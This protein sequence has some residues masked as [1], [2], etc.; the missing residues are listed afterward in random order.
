ML[1]I[2]INI[3]PRHIQLQGFADFLAG[4]LS[5][6]PENTAD[7]LELEVLETAAIGDTEHVS[8]VM[9]ACSRLGVHF[10]LDDFGTGYSSLTHFH[11]LPIDV[12]KIDQDFVRDMLDDVRDLDIVE[13]VL[14][15]AET[16]QRPVVAE[17]VETV[18]TGL[19][20]LQLGCRYAQGY[21][22]AI[23]VPAEQLPDWLAEWQ[24]NNIWHQLD[25]ETQ[26]SPEAFDLNVTIFSC[27]RW[28]E[29]VIRYLRDG[30][31]T[32]LPPL[33]DT[34]CQFARW[35]KGIC[36]KR[37]G[38]QPIYAFLPPKHR[39]VHELAESLVSQSDSGER[40][41]VLS[42]IDELKGLGEELIALLQKL[43]Q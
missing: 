32:E 24:T 19:M 35:Y 13:G 42:R 11:K 3:S 9:E 27:H 2:S 12:L 14:R 34:Q 7:H 40:E 8:Q 15:L 18:E 5:H 39:Q 10:S 43:S 16:L 33:S 38:N 41:R 26:N 23:P 30:S 21:G 31:A 1:P 37:Y 20:L 28:L 4:E 22:I 6:Y 36:R 25:Q 17:G 29:M